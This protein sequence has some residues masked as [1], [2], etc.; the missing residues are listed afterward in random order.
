MTPANINGRMLKSFWINFIWY[1]WESFF[2]LWNCSVTSWHQFLITQYLV[3][4]R[5]KTVQI[6]DWLWAF[7]LQTDVNLLWSNHTL[8]I[9]NGFLHYLVT[10][11]ALTEVVGLTQFLS[12]A[13]PKKDMVI[14]LHDLVRLTTDL[15][16]QEKWGIRHRPGEGWFK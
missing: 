6:T 13:F 3:M 2:V 1:I 9:S 12:M 5:V 15:D 8:Y 14:D 10:C 4:L 11:E 16:N 7:H